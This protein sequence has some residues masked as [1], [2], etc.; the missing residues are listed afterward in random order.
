MTVH[1][2]DMGMAKCAFGYD[3]PPSRWPEGHR[4]VRIQDQKR[5][6]CP[7]CLRVLDGRWH[8]VLRWQELSVANVTITLEPRPGY[9]DRGR[10]LAKI[11]AYGYEPV[12]LDEADGWPRYYF[13]EGRAKAEIQE[14][15]RAR[16]ITVSDWEAKASEV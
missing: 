12:H 4:W 5:A 3:D 8:P 6:T 13:D 14:W 15:L 1:V 2:F 10:W 7:D 9:C 16:G 11:S